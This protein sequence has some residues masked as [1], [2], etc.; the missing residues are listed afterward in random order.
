M[1]NQINASLKGLNKPYSGKNSR[2]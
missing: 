1:H 2:P